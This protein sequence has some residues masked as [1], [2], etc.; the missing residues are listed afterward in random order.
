MTSENSPKN[1]NE[2]RLFLALILSTGVLLVT[3]YFFR[4]MGLEQQPAPQPAI[5]TESYQETPAEPGTLYPPP[6]AL[7]TTEEVP[8][9]DISGSDRS[10]SLSNRDLEIRVSTRGGVLESIR[11]LQYLDELGEPLELIDQNAPPEVPRPMALEFSD[12]VLQRELASALY[13][14]TP[15]PQF[16][17]RLARQYTFTYQRGPLRIDRTLSLPEE[18]YVIDL[19]T[20]VTRAGQAVPFRIALGAG[21]GPATEATRADFLYPKASVYGDRGVVHYY[22]NDAEEAVAIPVAGWVSVDTQYFAR[23]LLS[24]TLS[25]ARVSTVGWTLPDGTGAQLVS[26][27]ASAGEARL[28]VGPKASEFLDTIDASLSEVIDYGILAIL[29]EPLLFLLKAVYGVVKNYGFA[30]IILTFLINLALIPIRY[31]QI[32]SMQKMSALQPKM[33]EIQNRYKNVAAKD[34][35]KQEMN[36]EVMAL[37]QEHG[38]N[39]LGSCLPLL[40]Q[41]PF[42]IAFYQMLSASVELRGAPFILWI[43]DLASY[44]PLY[45]TPIL[46]GATMVIQQKLSPAAG[47]PTQRRLMMLMPVIFTVFFLKVASGLALYFLFSNLFGIL[48]QKGVE[49]VSPELSSK[50]VK[51]KST[52]KGPS[53]GRVK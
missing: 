15:D 37:Y 46:M 24:E 31:K 49:R 17:G 3:P 42:L 9:E 47:D 40:V 12:P 22:V 50:P 18:G 27:S 43:Q 32:V 38:V 36:K 19:S 28:V 5:P 10:F 2:K 7:G 13:K 35:K 21:T 14:V 23:I 30:I 44:D 4:Y 11:L 51:R 52:P 41:M 26:A 48:F 33:K 20:R 39:P 53:R 8:V 6:L 1:E 25:D 45:V 34:P 29:V 16:G